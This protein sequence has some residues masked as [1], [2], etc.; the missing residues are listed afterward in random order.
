MIAT[1]LVAAA[2]AAAP[3]HP[4]RVP[5][6]HGPTVPAPIVM[7]TSCGVFRLD[8]DG[9]TTRLPRHWLAQHGD[10]TGR[11]FGARLGL[12]SN[13]AGR[14]ILLLQKRVVWRSHDLY[15]N[16]GG[17]SNY[18][19][20]QFAFASYRRGIF[21]TDL[22]SRERLVVRGRGLFPYT[23][24]NAGNLIVSGRG[25][26]LWLVSP[27]GTT[28]RRFQYRRR[29]GFSFDES[30]DS[31]YFVTPG[32]ILARAR[33]THVKLARPL[34][35]IDGAIS[36]LAPNLLAFSGAHAITV[37]KR[38]GAPVARTAWN[39][40]RLS[41][42]SGVSASTDGSA[43]AFRLSDAYPGAKSGTAT[44][45]IL[46]AGRTQAQAL[47]TYR[48]GPSGCAVGANLRW[49]G[50]WLLYTSYDGHIDAIDTT[51]A[52]VR[53]LTPLAKTLAHHSA[54]EGAGAAWASDFS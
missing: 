39:N 30:T 42:D 33:G 16:D 37:T 36:V 21:L 27:Q 2:L 51:S 3:A 43:V 25:H 19:P 32:G 1:A 29:N 52:I 23:F 45:Y 46:R 41:S 5:L 18:G 14:Y 49:H 8:P 12:R 26:A 13:R 17:G 50:H 53:D 44:V 54:N 34:R 28:L 9:N 40:R 22:K 31:L 48:L 6:P 24:T 38:D 15:P 20:H 7:W 10:G 11:R 47:R 4:C 35:R